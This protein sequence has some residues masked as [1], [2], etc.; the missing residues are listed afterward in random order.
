MGRLGSV[1]SSPPF[2]S[3]NK[4]KHILNLS[5]INKQKFGTN[6]GTKG[7]DIISLENSKLKIGR[8]ENFLSVLLMPI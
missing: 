7:V 5:R 2:Y 4:K 3:K 8:K 1:F 6:M